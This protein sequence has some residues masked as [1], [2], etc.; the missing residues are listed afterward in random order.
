MKIVIVANGYPDKWG[1]QW[2]CFEKD[3]AEALKKMGHQVS[4][5]YVDRRFVKCWRKLGNVRYVDNGLSIYGFILGPICGLSKISMKFQYWV[6]SRLFQ[7]VFRNYI[8]NEGLPDIIYAHYMY[9]I[10]YASY[11]KKKYK[12]PLVGM[13][14]WSKFN[15]KTLSPGVRLYGSI[16]YNNAD[17]LIAVSDI[18]RQKIKEHFGKDSI[19]VHNMVG[20]LFVNNPYVEEINSSRT[21]FISVGSLLPVK[22]YDILIEALSLISRDLNNWELRIIGEGK[23]HLRLQK[24]IDEKEL[25]DNIFLLGVKNKQEI[26]KY[27]SESSTYISSSRS[28]N[29]SVAV[30]EALSIGL[31]VV[32]TICGGIRECINVNNGLLVP[33]EN[34]YALANALKRMVKDISKYNRKSIADD[35]KRRF[36]PHVIAQQLTDIFDDLLRDK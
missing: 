25:S 33:I 15:M 14:H 1:P 3:Q 24:M 21:I 32:A 11:L 27:L 13:E 34:S 19:V 23:E 36:A 12:V 35:C 17:R 4:V 28:E 9:N 5:F 26:V 18:L 16:A 2:G 30:I 31:P 7:V 20:E 10:A 29:F 6:I 22:G 8:K